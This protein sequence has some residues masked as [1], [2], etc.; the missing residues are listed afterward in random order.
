MH[1]AFTMPQ[2]LDSVDLEANPDQVIAH[3][4][5]VVAN[6]DE[7]ASGSIRICDPDLQRRV[8]RL[9]RRR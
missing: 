5:D 9:A 2:N 7:L 4:Y 1:H 3:C 6:G 8:F